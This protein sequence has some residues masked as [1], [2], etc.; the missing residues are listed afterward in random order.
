MRGQEE[1]GDMAAYGERIGSFIRLRG[2]SVVRRSDDFDSGGS[3]NRVYEVWVDA[4]HVVSAQKR[5]DAAVVV[6]L[7]DGTAVLVGVTG[8]GVKVKAVRDVRPLLGFIVQS[9]ALS[10]TIE[11]EKARRREDIPKSS[12]KKDDD[13]TQ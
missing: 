12:P 3:Q 10:G 5:G 1:Q 9:Q 6:K 2:E 4:R 11:G 8:G 13:R 7:S